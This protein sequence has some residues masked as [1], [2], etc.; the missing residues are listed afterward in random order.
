MMQHL[1][2]MIVVILCSAC[3]RVPSQ[4]QA[5]L[6]YHG[7]ER[8]NNAIYTIRYS[9]DMDLL[10]VFSR[11][12]GEGQL[13]TMLI[14]SLDGDPVFSAEHVIENKFEGVIG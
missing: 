2:L 14:C 12:E 3:A 9:S 13:A 6:T 5:E 1:L 4:P 7:I 10:N 11:A 8:K